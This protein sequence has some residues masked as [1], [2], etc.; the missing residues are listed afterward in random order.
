[1]NS[2]ERVVAALQRRVPDRVP[3]IEPVIDPAIVK[4]MGFRSFN[5]MYDQL[6]LD[7]VT[8]NQLIEYPEGADLTIPCGKVITS[9]WGVT[10]QYTTEVMPIPIDHPLK[11]PEDLLTYEPPDSLFSAE[12][13]A[14]VA[15]VVQ[16]YKGK[17]AIIASQREVFGD[18]W[19]LRGMENYLMD[20]VENPDLVRRIAHLVTNVNKERCR[21]LIQ[22]GADAILMGDDYAYKT[23][24][25]MSPRLFRELLKPGIREVVAAAKQEGGYAIKHTDGNIWSIINDF[26][27]CGYDC[28]G[29]LEPGASMDLLEVKQRFGHRVCVLGQVDVDLLCR[30]TVHDVQAATRRLIERVSPGGGFILSSGNSIISAVRPE[31]YMAMIQTAREFGRYA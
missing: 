7:A 4:A 24:P 9:P 2:V 6:D 17:K 21:Q 3:V 26:V 5:E 10:L 27:D 20:M 29:P 22:A 11:C 12:Y 8:L 16:R 18:S 19:Y 13:M 25:L 23:G 1:M 15:D 31:N 14:R 30:G 28:L